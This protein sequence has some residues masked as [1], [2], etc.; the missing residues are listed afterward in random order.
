MAAL[1]LEF[2]FLLSINIVK[3]YTVKYKCKLTQKEV[4][5]EL[6]SL[7]EQGTLSAT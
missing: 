1:Q 2:Q 7:R 4:A 3:Q 5:V 6:C